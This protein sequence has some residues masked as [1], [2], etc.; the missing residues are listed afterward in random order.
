M[1]VLALPTYTIYKVYGALQSSEHHPNAIQW[2]GN[3]STI[4]EG[5]WT[6]TKSG[7]YGYLLLEAGHGERVGV[8]TCV[9]H[10]SSVMGTLTWTGGDLDFSF[11]VS[12]GTSNVQ[13][14]IPKDCFNC[15]T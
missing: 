5:I 3:G 1:R 14:P 11:S 4:P 2:D 15:Y 12:L 9:L 8:A 6:A 7:G 10:D 13:F